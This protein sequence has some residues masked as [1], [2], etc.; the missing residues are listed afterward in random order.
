M[1][2]RAQP[3]HRNSAPHSPLFARQRVK[4]PSMSAYKDFLQQ[5]KARIRV[6]E[7]VGKYLKLKR[8]G[9]EWVALSPFTKEKTPSFTINDEKQFWHCFSSGKHGDVF[10]FLTETQN[11]SFK[12][13]VEEVAMIAGMEVPRYRKM[14]PE[15]LEKT[16]AL[17]HAMEAAAAWFQETLAQ[18]E[19]AAARAYLKERGVAPQTAKQFRLGFAP[20]SRDAL[21]TTLLARGLSEETLLEAGL[22]IKPET[23]ANYDR[24]RNRIMFPI[25]NAQKKVVAFGGRTQDPDQR[26]KYMNS[27]ETP[28]FHKGRLLYGVAEAR[29]PAFDASQLILV[30]GYM[31]VLALHGAG[32][33]QVVAG[34]G[35][36]LTEEQLHLLWNIAPQP[37]ICLDGDAAGLR[38][39]RRLMERALPEI[40]AGRGLLFAYLPPGQDPDDL[41]RERGPDALRGIFAVAEP[42]SEALYRQE[43]EAAP[44]DTPEAKSLLEKRLLG[45]ARTIADSSLSRH[46]EQTFRQR[47]RDRFWKQSRGRGQP[48]IPGASAHRP[49][50]ALEHERILLGILIDAPVLFLKRRESV[51][52]AIFT[53]EEHGAFRDELLHILESHQ[54]GATSQTFLQK[55]DARFAPLMKAIYG[56]D[57]HAHKRR[58]PFSLEEAP[59][60]LL[61]C[62]DHYLHGQEME[63]LDQQREE[64]GKIYL[65][66]LKDSEKDP[67]KSENLYLQLCH[68]AE[69]AEDQFHHEALRLGE[70]FREALPQG[71]DWA[72]FFSRSLKKSPPQ[73]TPLSQPPDE[74]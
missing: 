15:V 13:A 60:L 29:K 49:D 57:G 12:E 52:R 20:A 3:I 46:Y 7:V 8:Q 6:S 72:G 31:D 41:L 28:L 55:M 35:T 36:A 11:M 66:N 51:E 40:S 39:G 27:P 58:L 19:G 4:L 17:L 65:R 45:L 2:L 53:H 47:L 73:E 14:P 33:P 56:E 63:A 24:F 25:E 61:R 18:S 54:E 38:A 21:K 62:L 59:D 22:L 26:A 9:H 10:S 43:V 50:G 37:I 30:E 23:G 1:G 34:M 16:E 5:L 64:A 44:Q 71:V 68:E 70:A 69:E 67:Q 74:E 32:I 42:L 48:A